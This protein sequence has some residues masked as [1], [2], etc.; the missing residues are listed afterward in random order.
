[1][2]TL[3]VAVVDTQEDDANLVQ[4]LLASETAQDVVFQCLIRDCPPGSMR[5]PDKAHSPRPASSP[6]SSCGASLSSTRFM[7]AVDSNL[8]RVQLL[9]QRMRVP[10]ELL[11]A[12][13]SERHDLLAA[14]ESSIMLF[15]RLH[16][17]YLHTTYDWFS[18]GHRLVLAGDRQMFPPYAD[19]HLPAY[20]QQQHLKGFKQRDFFSRELG[21]AMEVRGSLQQSYHTQVQQL[22]AAV[23]AQRHQ[24]D[25]QRR[26]KCGEE[27]DCS[28]APVCAP[29]PLAP[30]AA[31]VIA[32]QAFIAVPVSIS[33]AQRSLSASVGQSSVLEVTAAPPPEAP[34]P[35]HIRNV[36]LKKAFAEV[37]TL[38]EQM[39]RHTIQQSQEFQW[40]QLKS[41]AQQAMLV[42]LARIHNREA[43][44]TPL[45]ADAAPASTPMRLEV[46]W[47]NNLMVSRNVAPPKA[48]SEVQ[49][50]LPVQLRR[51]TSAGTS[52]PTSHPLTRVV[53]PVPPAALTADGSLASY[54]A[55]DCTRGFKRGMSAGVRPTPSMPATSAAG[56]PQAAAASTAVDRTVHVPFVSVLPRAVAAYRVSSAPVHRTIPNSVW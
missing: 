15:R 45:D 46:D 32:T 33:H 40:T 44:R 43:K 25:A 50:H 29:R 14:Y 53:T 11:E 2:S 13:A 31:E 17:A 38:R 18:S 19:R 27:E 55:G 22:G 1:M 26:K 10:V 47:L 28:V 24:F 48:T 56:Q 54:K 42:V 6:G 7:S 5:V 51:P 21:H 52:N 8:Q 4:W 37:A 9:P 35:I 36:I 3:P 20:L 30:P 12:E 16:P 41:I 49:R 39:T 23:G 34:A